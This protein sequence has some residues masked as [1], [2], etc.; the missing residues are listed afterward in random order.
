ML[1]HHSKAEV[2]TSV[3]SCIKSDVN[4][5]LGYLADLDATLA[6]CTDHVQAKN[7]FIRQFLIRFSNDEIIE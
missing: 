6:S 7:D 2:V 5:M 1:K 4:T 3:L